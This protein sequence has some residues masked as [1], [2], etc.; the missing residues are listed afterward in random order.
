M[1]PL[2]IAATDCTPGVVF[3]HLKGIFSIE[4]ESWPEDVHEFYDPM[5]KWLRELYNLHYWQKDVSN[6]IQSYI[7]DVKLNYFNSTSA[8]FIVEIFMEWKNLRQIA[9]TKIR[10]Y[11]NPK[12]TDM[13][14]CG[15]Q[16]ADMTG[17]EVELVEIG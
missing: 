4:G 1:Q 14:D 17:T 13:K 11:Y 5:L 16:M 3:D 8:R 7:L 10:W 6:D 9:S 2:I 12:D 15:L